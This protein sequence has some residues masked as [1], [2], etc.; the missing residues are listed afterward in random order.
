MRQDDKGRSSCAAFK[1]PEILDSCVW[2]MEG[3]QCRRPGG[4][5]QAGKRK[6]A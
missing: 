3:A 4:T 2:E 5:V 1:G 6:L